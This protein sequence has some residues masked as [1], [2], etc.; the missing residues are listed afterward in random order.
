M[1]QRRDPVTSTGLRIAQTQKLS[2]T[3]ERNLRRVYGAEQAGLARFNLSTT[4]AL[5]LERR[6]LVTG[7][8]NYNRGRDVQLTTAG[9]WKARDL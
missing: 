4:E 7:R 5:S 2:S 1:K 3:M 8:M 9:R 6:G